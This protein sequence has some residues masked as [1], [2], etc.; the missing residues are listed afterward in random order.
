MLYLF[1]SKAIYYLLISI[2]F[3]RIKKSLIIQIISFFFFRFKHKKCTRAEK[4]ITNA[5]IVNF[6]ALAVAGGLNTR[7]G[8]FNRSFF[9]SFTVII[10]SLW[11]DLIK[12]NP[13]SWIWWPFRAVTEPKKLMALTIICLF[14]QQET[15]NAVK[16][17]NHWTINHFWNCFE[18]RLS[19]VT[20]IS[21]YNLDFS[22]FHE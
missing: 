3:P 21:I 8:P 14:N 4:E 17:K 1:L 10:W 6:I 2:A 7:A 19:S 9:F 13:G 18:L 20:Y 16:R 12:A 22:L 5:R 15:M 11:T